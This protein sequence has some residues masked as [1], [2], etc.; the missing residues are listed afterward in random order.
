MKTVGVS[1]LLKELM[2]VYIFASF[3]GCSMSLSKVMNGGAILHFPS[4]NS[5]KKPSQ[6]WVKC[7]MKAPISQVLLQT[8]LLIVQFS[9]TYLKHFHRI[10]L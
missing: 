2:M 8:S 5:P 1:K 3:C 10:F 9:K 6:Q 4:K 7:C